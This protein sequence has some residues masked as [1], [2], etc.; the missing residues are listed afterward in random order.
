M[1]TLQ[2][3]QIC[4]RPEH[5]TQISELLTPLDNT[6]AEHPELCEYPVFKKGY[7]Q[8]LSLGE[9]KNWGFLSPKFE[10]KTKISIN[11]FHDWAIEKLSGENC[12]N[13]V[14]IN[15]TPILES[16]WPNVIIQGERCHPGL[17]KLLNFGLRGLG[18]ES[19]ILNRM[20]S[21]TTF[22]MSNYFAG[23]LIFW[24]KY[25]TFVDNFVEVIEKDPDCKKLMFE[26]SAGYQRDSSIPYY[27]FVVER[28]FSV[29]L[30]LYESEISSA[31]YVYTSE[32]LMSKSHQTAEI[33][34]E[35][36]ALSS[37]KYQAVATNNINLV[38]PWT[39]LR[40]QFVQR[41]PYIFNV[42]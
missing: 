30:N 39:T 9:N 2:L 41:H 15:A 22:A 10:Q 28:L 36:M 20:M 34:D 17:A 16:I 6:A 29:F 11:K 14:F 37:I 38:Q 7:L 26:T 19:D 21:S 27:T 4:H 31:A 12:P 13:V 18:I 1:K 32:E 3:H 23:D 33:I 35:I 42:E 25:I 40:H 8:Q 24:E 5:F